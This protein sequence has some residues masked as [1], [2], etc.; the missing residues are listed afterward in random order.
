MEL[1]DICGNFHA[2][3]AA[4]VALAGCHSIQFIGPWTSEANALDTWL[5]IQNRNI[6]TRSI[7]PCP[8]G[9]YGIPNK[10]C[11]CSTEM[12]V[13]WYTW[14]FAACEFDINIEVFPNSADEVI[15]WLASNL[16]GEVDEVVLMRVEHAYK[17]AETYN[18]QSLD[19]ASQILLKE[20]IKQFRLSYYQVKRTL[21]VA[22]TIANLAESPGIKTYHL[23]ES[24]QYR[25]RR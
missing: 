9:Y 12:V 16:K 8:C 13:H 24:L 4:E 15:E 2:K 20:A 10:E 25:P 21:A 18:S 22:R 5:Q 14:K 17:F 11:T 19:D 6:S 23:A 1:R 7:T 3:R